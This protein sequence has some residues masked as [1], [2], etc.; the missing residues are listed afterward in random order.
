MTPKLP[1]ETMRRCKGSLHPGRRAPFGRVVCG[2]CAARLRPLAGFRVPNHKAGVA[3][4]VP[5]VAVAA[6]TEDVPSPTKRK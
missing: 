1:S 2:V 5:P 3:R 4:A 6:V